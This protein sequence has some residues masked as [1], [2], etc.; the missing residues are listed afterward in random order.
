MIDV[1]TSLA[2][3]FAAALVLGTLLN[4]ASQAAHA[5]EK[6]TVCFGAAAAAL[7]P[8]AKQQSFY[9]T[10]G[11]EAEMRPFPSG[12]LALEA[13]LADQCQM[14]AAAETPVIHHSLR[15]SA[16]RIIAVIATSNNFERLIVRSDRAILTL[17]DLRGRRI[18]VPEFTTAH[19]F[20]DI[21]LL[22]NGLAPQD[23][24]KVYL[25]A[26]DVAAAF[27]RGEVDAA[28]HWEPHIQLLAAEFGA[29][30]KVFSAPGLH[31]S[32]FLLVG[33]T[34]YVNQ[35]PAAIE[36]VLRALLRAERFAK[37]QPAQAKAL[38]ARTN[39]V[40]SGEID[41]V[42]PLNDFRVTLD[43]SLLFILENAARWEIGL[44]PAAQ[45]PKL[46]NYLDFIYLD[47]MKKVKPEALTIIH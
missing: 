43:Q 8:L 24:T 46:P 14:A 30:A 29:K 4:L 10:E 44:L 38:T 41:V 21:Y 19:Y 23:V 17:A 6:V 9:A 36:R 28:A 35:N 45:R 5:A 20:L 25:P 16:L 31:V 2:R 40:G 37:E 1:V 7:V 13:M 32:P 12:K 42:W 11:V 26:Q 18:A 27:R 3:Q 22:A 39:G 33:R 34:D 15:G 47:G